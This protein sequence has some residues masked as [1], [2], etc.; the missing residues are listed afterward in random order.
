MLT[1]IIMGELSNAIIK[2]FWAP[3]YDP[4]QND[5]GSVRK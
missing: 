3:Q 2:Q 5:H 4:L 1:I